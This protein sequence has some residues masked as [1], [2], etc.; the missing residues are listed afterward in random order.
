MQDSKII[1]A[2]II[3][4][5]REWESNL[6]PNQIEMILWVYVMDASIRADLKAFHKA[7]T[8]EHS[9]PPN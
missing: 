7:Y 8:Q 6:E 4:N 1:L 5:A 2:R 9:P 3:K